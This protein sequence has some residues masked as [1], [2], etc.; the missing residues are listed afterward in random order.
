M[1]E[2][3]P[4]ENYRVE[5]RVNESQIA[6]VLVGQHGEL[7]VAALPDQ[8]FPFEVE[9]ITPV[10]AARDGGYS[11]PTAFWNAPCRWCDRCSPSPASCCGSC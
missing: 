6:D 11:I 3:A 7:V 2:I 5:L 9:R 4:L 1:F 8:A 10:A